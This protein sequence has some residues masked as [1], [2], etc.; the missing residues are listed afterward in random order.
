MTAIQ[1]DRRSHV[2]PGDGETWSFLGTTAVLC[3]PRRPVTEPVVIELTMPP[4]S[5]P[6][7]HVHDGLDDSFYVL[8]GTLAVQ[9]GD[10]R[11]VARP[12]TY[13]S[14]PAGIPH[15]FRVMGS[16]EARVLLVHAD[17]SFL[18]LVQE[19]GDCVSESASAAPGPVSYDELAE[20]NL[21]HGSRIIGDSMDPVD[22]AALLA[23]DDAPLQHSGFD[24]IEVR[25]T[26]LRVSE[27]WYAETLGLVRG[28]GE[29]TD[30]GNGHVAM[31]HPPSRTV[32][33]LCAEGPEADAASPFGHVAWRVA[34]RS[35][36]LRWQ[37]KLTEQG[38][39]PGAITDAPYGS[40]F[41]TRDP[42]GIE[43]ELFAPAS[44]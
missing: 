12:G 31:I 29:V 10:E 22:A 19:V 36:L 30:E 14:L 4:D 28:S 2:D 25:V 3:N 9:C 34:D 5:S 8:S 42:D 37:A 7:L 23:A 20:A 35:T 15:T 11:F 38:R 27:P 16:I 13:V 26:D 1:T 43:I 40:G 18:G 33:A 21:R 6:P 41:V 44:G 32:V 24:H 39:N 17:D